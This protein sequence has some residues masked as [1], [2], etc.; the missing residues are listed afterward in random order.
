[1]FISIQKAKDK[2]QYNGITD[3]TKGLSN[4]NTF[5]GL[6]SEIFNFGN[7]TFGQILGVNDK[8]ITRKATLIPQFKEI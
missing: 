5:E 7:N 8:Q 3:E 6:R 1:M 4:E 2:L